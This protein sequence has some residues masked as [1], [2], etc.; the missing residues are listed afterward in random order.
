MRGGP[1]PVAF[2]RR[3]ETLPWAVRAGL[4]LAVALT[5]VVW[6][7]LR[8]ADARALANMDPDLR[9]ELFVRSR[10]EA[11]ALCARPDLSE[12]C[13]ARVEFLSLFPECDQSCRELVARQ[14][15]RATR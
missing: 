2:R 13:R 3:Q 14:R 12:Q 10:A 15:G 5:V 1:I 6:A 11:E 8:N 9:G 7:W 4:L